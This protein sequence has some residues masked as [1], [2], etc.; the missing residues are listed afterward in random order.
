MLLR[1][2]AAHELDAVAIVRI[3]TASSGWTISVDILDSIGAPVIAWARRREADDVSGAGGAGIEFVA[4]RFSFPLAEEEAAAAQP[5]DNDSPEVSDMGA[6]AR[7]R[8][9]VTDSSILYGG[10]RIDGAND[11]WILLRIVLV[12]LLVVG[13]YFIVTFFGSPPA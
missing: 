9:W 8:L 7:P 3:S 10:A 12:V 13:G 6:A 11:L 1:Y 4:A 5:A 2:S